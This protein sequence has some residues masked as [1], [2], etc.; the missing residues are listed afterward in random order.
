MYFVPNGPTAGSFGR[1]SGETAQKS[2]SLTVPVF[3]AL[4]PTKG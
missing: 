1:F 3:L 2:V 4:N